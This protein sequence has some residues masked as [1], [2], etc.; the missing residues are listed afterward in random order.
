MAGLQRFY[1]RVDIRPLEASEDPL[2]NV[3][4]TNNSPSN[5]NTAASPI[6][7][8]V[9]GSLSATGVHHPTDTTR[10]TAIQHLRP[11]P[12]WTTPEEHAVDLSK[13]PQ[14]NNFNDITWYGVTLDKR[15]VQ[16]PMGT[17]LAVPS[18][19]LAAA[20]AAEWEAVQAPTGIQPTQMPLMRLACTA[21]DQTSHQMS[22]YQQ[23]CLQFV[24]TDTLCFWADPADDT[25]R[26]LY[27]AQ[28]DHW[29]D[30]HER[31]TQVTGGAALATAMGSTESVLARRGLPHPPAI[32]QYASWFVE[33]LDAWHLTALHQLATEA[34][35]FWLAWA[36]LT[37]LSSV[38]SSSSSS[39]S[40]A[41]AAISSIPLW[42]G[43][44]DKAIHALRLEEEVQIEQWGLV[45]GAQDYD[46]LNASVSVRAALLL[47]ETLALE[48]LQRSAPSA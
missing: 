25:D 15:L 9:D 31:V 29:T 44:V 33:H 38:S 22:I 21:L 32:H 11:R 2:S 10:A 40:A 41:A 26:P 42:N 43:Q 45:E 3:K 5:S 13:Q 14:N 27:Q 28:T 1:R 17:T 36:L 24:P 48:E 6:A 30:L 34:K 39:S 7:A 20:I 47:R 12:V 16:T 19:G 35:S 4:G 8:G 18:E 23:Q 46:R 37:Q